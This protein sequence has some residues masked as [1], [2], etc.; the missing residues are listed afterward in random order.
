MTLLSALGL[1]HAINGE[2]LLPKVASSMTPSCC[3]PP[4]SSTTPAT[5]TRFLLV[6]TP[7][8]RHPR[9]GGRRPQSIAPP[10][11]GLAQDGLAAFEPTFLDEL[12]VILR[13]SFDYLQRD[14]DAEPDARAPGCAT[15]PAAPSTSAS[16]RVRWSSPAAR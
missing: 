14:G 9:P 4:T 12:A 10:L 5:R 8:G 11:V 2:Q 3:A 7:L 15:P 6:G 1:S 16:R 13:W